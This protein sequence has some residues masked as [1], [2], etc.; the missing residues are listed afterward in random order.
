MAAITGPSINLYRAT[1]IKSA[2][3]LYIKT[4]M[5][6][7]RAYT[8]RNMRAAA[9]EYTGKVYPRSKKGLQRAHDDLA[10]VIEAAKI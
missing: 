5:Q 2:L 1:V 3:G 8:P 9:S 7:N 4:G 6:V 10:A